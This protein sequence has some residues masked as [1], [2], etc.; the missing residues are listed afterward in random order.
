[1]QPAVAT[2]IGAAFGSGR[3]PCIDPALGAVLGAT[4]VSPNARGMAL[5][6]A[7]AAG[8]GV[9][10]LLA[11]CLCRPIAKASTS[12]TASMARSPFSIFELLP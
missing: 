6:V 4:A 11:S 9:P 5:L 7:Y 3:T 10:F 1:M 8:L 12:A 2:A